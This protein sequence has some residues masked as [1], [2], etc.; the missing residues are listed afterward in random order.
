M[1]I[2]FTI[3]VTNE[4]WLAKW[5]D[6]KALYTTAVGL[7][8]ITDDNVAILLLLLLLLLIFELVRKSRNFKKHHHHH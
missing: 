6:G 7:S 4:S 3:S 5:L 2:L 8:T 1:T